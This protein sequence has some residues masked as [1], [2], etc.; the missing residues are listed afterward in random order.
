MWGGLVPD[1]L[2]TLSRLLATPARRRAATSRSRACTPARP[3][4]S[5]TPRS[6][7][8]PSPAPLD[9]VELDRRRLDRRAAL[10]QAGA[11]A[12]PASTPPRS[13]A[14]ATPWSRPPAPRSRMRI[15]PGD[16]TANAVD[17]PARAP[18]GARRRG[19]PSSRV[20]VVDTGEATQIDAT[21]PAYDAARAAFARGLGRHRAGRHGR[22]RLDPVHRRVPRGVPARP[23]C[24][25]P[26]S[27]TPTPAPTAPTRAC[28]SPSSSGSARR[29]AAAAQPGQA[30][31]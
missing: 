13:T 11:H 18:R 2:M 17:V 27:R 29:G 6:G 5:T 28:T 7:S 15:A 20:T 22:R 9:G 26:A 23:A 21:G 14:P 12:S 19:A 25:S 4:T 31:D 3:P 16:T 1:A 8:A 10:D 24:W 30:L